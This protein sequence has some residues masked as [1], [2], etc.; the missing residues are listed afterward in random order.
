MAKHRRLSR[1]KYAISFIL[2]VI[3]T[4][5][6]GYM[7]LEGYTFFE[8]LYMTM[9]TISTVGFQEVHPLDLPGKIFTIVLII[10]GLGIFF[11]AISVLAATII[12]GELQQ[13]FKDYRTKSGIKK[14]ENHVI[15]C[16]YGRNGSQAAKELITFKHPFI[17]IEQDKQVILKNQDNAIKFI[18]GDSTLDDIL[19]SAGVKSAKALITTLPIDADNLFV[20]LS[21]KALNKN[22]KIISRASSDTS[23]SKLRVAGANNVIMPEKV[24][25]A[26]MATI[27]IKPDVVEFLNR[28]AVQEGNATNLEEIVCSDLSSKYRDKTIDELEIRKISGA[29]IVGYKTPEGDYIINPLPNTILI[30]HS[31]LFV[32]GTPEQIKKMRQMLKQ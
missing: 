19:L 5:I 31:K 21:A 10:S 7:F 15:V 16:G 13:Y 17:V 23:E 14:M 3:M 25:G 12:E 4:G 27:V 32:L 22:L 24:G 18:E 2:L 9:I 28:I 20:T 29:N 11:Y 6:C 30:P 1:V 8:A 26:H